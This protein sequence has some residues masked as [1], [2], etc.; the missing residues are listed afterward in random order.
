MNLTNRLMVEESRLGFQG[1]QLNEIAS[2]EAL[3]AKHGGTSNKTQKH[4]GNSKFKQ[5]GKC[6]KCGS[7]EHWKRD[8][9]QS[10]AKS[11]VKNESSNEKAFFG[12]MQSVSK[13]DAWYVDSGATNHMCNRRDWF[14][15]YEKLNEPI[16]VILGN[17]NVMRAVGRGDLNALSYTGET[18]IEKTLKNVLYSADLYANLFSTTKA[19]DNGHTTWS[20]KHQFK[21]LDGER[22]V[23]VGARKGGIFQMMF[24]IIESTIDRS[25]A[26]IAV[27]QNSLR[28]SHERLGHQNLIHVRNFLKNN[29]IDFID[30]NFDC[31]GCA[32][33]KQHRL[34]FGMRLEKSTVCGEIIHADVCGPIEIKSL[35]GSRYFVLFKDDYSHFR[36]VFF[37][38]HKSEVIDKFKVVMKIAEKQCGHSIKY[39]QSDNGTEFINN[40]AKV[41]RREWNSASTFHCIYTGAKWLY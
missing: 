17:G 33:G 9:K 1:M 34:S 24:K 3:M 29:N 11:T 19:L 31:D 28:I 38:K 41:I 30:E 25:M 6:F 39:L 10:T 21:L 2:G 32:Y 12:N 7:T 26:N 13:R 40:D 15:N 37:I 14:I 5:R 36:F 23:A 8:C 27:K 4:K 22:V 35:A 18:W 20:D 16:K